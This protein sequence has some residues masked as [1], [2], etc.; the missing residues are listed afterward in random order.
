MSGRESDADVAMALTRVARE[1]SGRVRALLARRLG[2]VDLA[3]E[4]VQD[5]LLEAARTWTSNGV[6]SNPAG[7]L[8][9]V[10]KRRAI[11]RQRRATSAQRNAVEAART[12]PSDD[13]EASDGR[14]YDGLVPDEGD[15]VGDEQLRL[16]LL[17]CHPALDL[18][19]QVVLTLRL[20][21][22]L[23]T[24][25][26]ASAFLVPE[27]TLAQRIV[28]AKRKIRDAG[29][30]LSLPR[31]L[32]ARI[33]A[34]LA[35]LYLVFNEGYLA[36][37]DRDEAVRVDLVNEAVRLTSLLAELAPDHAEVD[38]LLALEL[39][40]RSRLATRTDILGD[41]VLLDRQDRSRWDLVAIL[42]ANRVL[43][44][45]MQ[46]MRPGPYQLQAIIAGHHANARTA[47][48]TDWPAI[49]SLYR[50]LVSMTASPVVQLN[51]AI[52]VAMADGPNA[53]L[54]MIDD[55]TGLDRYH[56]FHAARGE[57]LDRAGHP[58]EAR[59]AFE[60][61]RSLAEHPA[62]RRHLDRRSAELT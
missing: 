34:V 5:A 61:A 1:E 25:E 2:D 16:V 35:V 22:G 62:E 6:P 56:L 32:G 15:P 57:L 44:R 54:A 9:H 53:G 17:C 10:A 51:H 36:R 13:G 49:A 29:I 59:Q 40:H 14:S 52:A 3:D 42:D 28:R 38:G 19:A 50:Q 47:G 27:A 30:P 26:I 7:W 60:T 12:L 4:S 45:A 33:D 46:R 21:G 8:M 58:E 43:Q 20:V 31:D 39:F 18:D 41:L 48:D 24:T 37:G 11:D 23:T 55:L